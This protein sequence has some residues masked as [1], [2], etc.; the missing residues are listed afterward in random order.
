MKTYSNRS[1]SAPP[2]SHDRSEALKQ[3]EGAS[4]FTLVELSIVIVIIG[5]IIAGITAGQSLV[6]TSQLRS[7]GSKLIQYESA[8]IQFK[9]QYLAF[10]G[11]MKN[12]TSY[13]GGV[14]ADGDGN[15]LINNTGED[16]RSIQH[17]T[18]A[19]LISDNNNNGTAYYNIALNRCIMIQQHGAAIYSTPGNNFNAISLLSKN[20]ASWDGGVSTIEGQN[21]DTKYDDGI[22]TSGKLVVFSVTTND[23]V[24][25][26][27]GT[28]NA[29]RS[30][31][32][33]GSYN[34]V[35]PAVQCTLSYWIKLRS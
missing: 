28:T 8:I 26:S 6:K 13:W 1:G 21:Y 17:L 34:L 30:Y 7:N 24:K 9:Y 15:K 27:D 2:H 18:L 16:T 14:T 3:V 11:D 32:G 29:A 10:P 31:T 4:G 23:C 19:G 12:A 25:Q 33:V 35:Q 5:L 20:C 22:P